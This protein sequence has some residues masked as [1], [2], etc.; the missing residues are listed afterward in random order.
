[1]MNLETPLLKLLA[2]R[3]EWSGDD[4]TGNARDL[5][6]VLRLVH[7]PDG[8]PGTLKVALNLRRILRAALA[9]DLT[10][11]D[12]ARIQLYLREL[13]WLV[14]NAE[15]FAAQLYADDANRELFLRATGRN[16]VISQGAE[17]HGL[18][19]LLWEDHPDRDLIPAFRT[20]QQHA[21]LSQMTVMRYWTAR[22]EWQPGSSPATTLQTALYVETLAIRHFVMPAYKGKAAYLA[23][24]R[25]IPS[26][27]SAPNLISVLE[28]IL[29]RQNPT[30][31]D[32]KP[33]SIYT[34][35]CAI[36]WLLKR[37][38]APDKLRRPKKTTVSPTQEPINVAPPPAPV[39]PVP[40][41]ESSIEYVLDRSPVDDLEDELSEGDIEDETTGTV[42]DDQN[43]D[44]SSNTSAAPSVYYRSRWNPTEVN[45]CLN[46]GT[47]PADEL[48]K[49]SIYLSHRRSGPR[50]GAS[51]SS[52]KNQ[53]LR[54]SIGELPL[55]LV[56]DGMQILKDASNRGGVAEL[57][58]YLRAA[59]ILRTGATGPAMSEMVVRAD[60]PSDI[61]SLT[62]VLPPPGS[63]DQ[64]E[65]VVP[66]LP[67]RL[68]FQSE[69]LYGCWECAD[70]F[71]LPD[72]TGISTI[73]RRLLDLQSSGTWN[74]EPVQ[75][76]DRPQADFDRKLRDCLS[77]QDPNRAEIL[78]SIFTFSRLGEVRFHQIYKCAGDNV[79]PATYLTMKEHPTGEVTRFYETLP[80]ETLQSL[81]KQS[82]AVLQRNLNEL[83]LESPLDLT[84]TP[85]KTGG[86]IGSPFCP[87]T[88]TLRDFLSALRQDLVDINSR[89]RCSVDPE[90]R[91]DP[92]DLILLHNRYITYC[93]IGYNLATGHRPVIGGYTSPKQVEPRNL[94]MG[95][96]DKGLRGRLVPISTVTFAQMLACADY[97]NSFPL[98]T[99]A[100][101]RDLP[102]YLLGRDWRVQ[103]I[104]PSSL[105]EHLPFVPN[106]GR[107]YTC[108]W[109]AQRIL[110]GDDHITIEY[111]K[112]FLGHAAEGE[113]R[114]GP[115]SAFN[116][117]TY[118]RSMR[119][120]LDDL[121]K[122]IGYW[123]IDI[124][125]C[126]IPAYDPELDCTLAP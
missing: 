96:K 32:G 18:W 44:E 102:L 113:D 88:T 29:A 98:I 84:L 4:A 53:M 3:T 109:I 39:G 7:A 78:K 57:Q 94:L 1:M 118:A 6:E 56:A 110:D 2:L 74:G 77:R 55:E 20:L 85:S 11:H 46:S 108:S 12:R 62:F 65:W 42:D 80:I 60:H 36:V 45:D 22:P 67:L 90:Y 117:Q 43:E 97:L 120:A 59:I 91:V 121:L 103:E 75:P 87:T 76:F 61:K 105:Q 5:E 13:R 73:M 48:P 71:V 37:A 125:G 114:A 64:G 122:E 126:K 21:L 49:S 70:R 115:H 41:P 25:Q 63:R 26:R 106:F 68:G 104:S 23:V 69:P 16:P 111:L 89:L 119:D 81:D 100:E 66:A 9:D 82:V 33:A 8:L 51:W 54:W 30:Q 112:E 34:D 19:S 93:Y 116:Y 17:E 92:A 50:R 86:Y 28:K 123:P 35:L 83:G 40:S 38:S 95:I 124:T 107:H 10:E 27:I 14:H 47:H 72:F 15:Q 24:L 79:V 58:V 101:R 31:P 52:Q 99:M